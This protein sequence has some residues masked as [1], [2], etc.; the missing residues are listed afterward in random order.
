MAP[1]AAAGQRA[2][3]GGPRGRAMPPKLFL[4]IASPRRSSPGV[5]PAADGGAYAERGGVTVRA[6]GPAGRTSRAQ[7]SVG[8]GCKLTGPPHNS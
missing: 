2:D 8:S 3:A 4:D 6:R 1:G 7:S 5:A